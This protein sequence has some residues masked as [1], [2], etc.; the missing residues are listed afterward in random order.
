MKNVVEFPK[1][2]IVRQAQVDVEAIELAK[3]RS[4][5]TFADNIMDELIENLAT[6]IENSGIDIEEHAFLKDF[7]LTVDALRATIYRTFGLPHTLHSF[8]DENVKIISRETGEPIDSFDDLTVVD[9]K[10]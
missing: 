9:T 10:E 2:K 8:I 6:D 7:S 1:N 3:E 4:L 5:F